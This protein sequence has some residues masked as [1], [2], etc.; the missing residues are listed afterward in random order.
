[1]ELP[2]ALAMRRYY[3]GRRRVAELKHTGANTSRLGTRRPLG[4]ALWR[5]DER[6][7]IDPG[8][9]A[10]IRCWLM[11]QS[12]E[13][14]CRREGRRRRSVARVATAR[15]PGM[16]DLIRCRRADRQDG[17]LRRQS[18]DRGRRAFGVAHHHHAR[19]GEDPG[20]QFIVSAAAE[21]PHRQEGGEATGRA[22]KA[23]GR[24][25]GPKR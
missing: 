16:L 20:E 13:R 9:L 8:R 22:G 24:V 11:G 17:F 5:W 23:R 21:A 7:A 15:G 3:R 1:M 10:W 14:G 19:P 6:R 4:A 25:H 12:R 18:N 2:T